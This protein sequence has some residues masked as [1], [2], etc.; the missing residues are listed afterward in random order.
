MPLWMSNDKEMRVADMGEDHV[1]INIFTDEYVVGLMLNRDEIEGLCLALAEYCGI[2]LFGKNNNG[3]G[4]NG[5]FND[6][7]SS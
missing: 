2:G 7:L 5:S 4:N 1:A 3:D 6:N